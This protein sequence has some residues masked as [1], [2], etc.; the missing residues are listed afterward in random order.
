MSFINCPE[1]QNVARSTT[2]VGL[3][4]ARPRVLLTSLRT[5]FGYKVYRGFLDCGM[6]QEFWFIS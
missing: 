4:K 1:S 3:L 5:N 6:S 2:G